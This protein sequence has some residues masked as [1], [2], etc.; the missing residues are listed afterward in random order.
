MGPSQLEA[1]CIDECYQL[2]KLQDLQCQQEPREWDR[3]KH[4]G[5]T[6]ETK[7]LSLLPYCFHH[8]SAG[9]RRYCDTQLDI[10]K[11]GLRECKQLSQNHRI[12]EV[13]MGLDARFAVKKILDTKHSFRW[14]IP[15][16]L[17]P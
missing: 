5:H 9:R 10:G 15:I 2:A 3:G 7:V 4:V 13:G 8:S 12:T 17:T 16:T 6:L 1:L 11:L 14:L